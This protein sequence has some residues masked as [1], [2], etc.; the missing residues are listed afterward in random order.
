MADVFLCK[1]AEALEEHGFVRDDS[2]SGF[3]ADI[4]IIFG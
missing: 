3:V 1:I 4:F 2:Y